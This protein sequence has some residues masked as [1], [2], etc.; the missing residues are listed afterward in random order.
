VCVCV[1]PLLQ[2]RANKQSLSRVVVNGKGIV[3]D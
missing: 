2:E 3:Y 1:S